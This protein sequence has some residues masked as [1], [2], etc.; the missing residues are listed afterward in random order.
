MTPTE[1]ALS[2]ESE[3][4]LDPPKARTGIATAAATTPAIAPMTSGRW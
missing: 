3:P 1:F 4:P 2:R